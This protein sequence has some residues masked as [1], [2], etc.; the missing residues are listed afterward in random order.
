M[1]VRTFL[2]AQDVTTDAERRRRLQRRSAVRSARRA[3]TSSPRP[4]PILTNNTSEFSAHGRAALVTAGQ[5]LNISTRLR[6]LTGDNVLIGGFIILGTEPKQVIVRA[7]GPAL[8]SFGVADPL[9]DPILEL[10]LSRRLGR[11]E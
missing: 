4:R 8:G 10:Q 9:V 7:I 11:D 6:V 2:G 1:K 3:E 5:L